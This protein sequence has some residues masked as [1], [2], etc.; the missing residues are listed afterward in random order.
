MSDPF[1]YA[2]CD[3]WRVL[4]RRIAGALG[5]RI[6]LYLCIPSCGLFR[7]GQSLIFTTA[8]ADQSSLLFTDLHSAAFDTG[9]SALGQQL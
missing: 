2:V 3:I 7:S 5:D 6:P 4:M 1:T 9:W 8:A